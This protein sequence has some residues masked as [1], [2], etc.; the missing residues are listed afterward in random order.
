MAKCKS[1]ST[2]STKGTYVMIALSNDASHIHQ[3]PL[4]N[5]LALKNTRFTVEEK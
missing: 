2:G 1:L 5:Q 3:N 4:H